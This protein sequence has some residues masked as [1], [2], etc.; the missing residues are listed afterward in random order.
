MAEQR[1]DGGLQV[2]FA[3]RVQLTQTCSG[4]RCLV[5]K[6]TGA[7]RPVIKLPG[8]IF[9]VNVLRLQVEAAG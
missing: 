6:E 8:V 1:V 2:G 4:K 9:T 3:P 5:G 7:K